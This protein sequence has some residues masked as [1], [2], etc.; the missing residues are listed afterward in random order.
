MWTSNVRWLR[1][2][3]MTAHW[4]QS[5]IQQPIFLMSFSNHLLGG[6]IP[7]CLA[8]GRLTNA[9][10][11][12]DFGASRARNPTEFEPN[13][14]AWPPNP[15]EHENVKAAWNASPALQVPTGVI[16]NVATQQKTTRCMP[17]HHHPLSFTFPMSSFIMLL[18]P[19]PRFQ[20]SLRPLPHPEDPS[21][22]C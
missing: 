15:C 19:L 21:C 12:F 8:W 2:L 5:A 10:S 4:I 16:M 3:H 1:K 13:T 6:K 11:I 20:L 14:G 17:Y 9:K 7:A 22:L 18:P